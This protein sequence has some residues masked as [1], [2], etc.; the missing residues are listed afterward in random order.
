MFLF[1]NFFDLFSVSCQRHSV[2]PKTNKNMNIIEFDVS[3]SATHMLLH[4]NLIALL[5][6]VYTCVLL[7][8][9]VEIQRL[10]NSSASARRSVNA[11]SRLYFQPQHIR[12]KFAG[13]AIT[14]LA[15]Y[16][17]A[18]IHKHCATIETFGHILFDSCA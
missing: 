4:L 12:I 11:K 8:I 18:C 5:L 10:Q 6:L 3:Y 13:K 2:R 15:E 1:E 14:N 7:S 17:C 16:P 9:S